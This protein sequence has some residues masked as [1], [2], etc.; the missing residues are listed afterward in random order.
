MT[1][2]EALSMANPGAKIGLVKYFYR[3]F[4]FSFSLC[5]FFR[6]TWF[7]DSKNF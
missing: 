6:H 7:V 3:V 2:S 1:G 5:I 4:T